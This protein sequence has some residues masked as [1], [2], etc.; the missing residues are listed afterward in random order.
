MA[1]ERGRHVRILTHNVAQ[2]VKGSL[3]VGSI[4]FLIVSIAMTLIGNVMPGA[5]ILARFALLLGLIAFALESLP[6]IGPILS[7]IPAL[8]LALT[9]G[10]ETTIVVSAFYFIAFN[11]E[12]PSSCPRSRASSSASVARPCW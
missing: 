5:E 4:M 12:G 7:Y 10:I 3:M 1:P 9:V 11:V 2:Y 8:I 6:Q